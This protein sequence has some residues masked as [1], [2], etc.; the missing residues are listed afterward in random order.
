MYAPSCR[1]GLVS[2]RSVLGKRCHLMQ[3]WLPQN[4]SKNPLGN[5]LCDA[6]GHDGLGR[7]GKEAHS[8]K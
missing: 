3:L 8:L 7:N 4:L 5:A 2:I 1:T 6:C